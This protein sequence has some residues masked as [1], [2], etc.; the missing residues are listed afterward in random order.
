MARRALP[1]PSISRWEGQRTRSARSTEA[2][3]VG[4]W[5]L[6]RYRKGEVCQARPS[7][8][9][10]RSPSDN[11]FYFAFVGECLYFSFNVELQ[12]H[13]SS[14]FVRCFLQNYTS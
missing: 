7:S 14:I 5:L 13:W 4:G 10:D 8:S 11:L 1:I 12:S 9:S 2:G 3:G 6:L